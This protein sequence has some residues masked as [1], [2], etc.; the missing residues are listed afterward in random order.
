MD[1]NQVSAYKVIEQA[2]QAMRRGD[3]IAARQFA[4]Q[5]ALAAPELEEVW[6]TLA[7]LAAPRASVEY[8]QQALRIN[9]QSQRAQK[10]L[11]WAM[12]RLQAEQPSAAD[13]TPQ[14][15]EKPY[16]AEP[17]SPPR[18][19]L[20]GESTEPLSRPLAAALQPH[21]ARQNASTAPRR[22]PQPVKNQPKSRRIGK[23]IAYAAFSV[24]LICLVAGVL[25]ASRTTP[26]AALF[27]KP[28]SGPAWAPAV[29]SKGVEAPAQPPTLAPTLTFL[30]TA[31][32]TATASAT[33]TAAPTLT[34]TT[35]ATETPLPSA[36]PLPTFTPAPTDTPAPTETPSI[37]PTEGPS[38]TPLPTDTA[39]PTA[40]L[41]T[42][43]YLPSLPSSERWIEVNL[44]QQMVYAYE[45]S[46]LVNSF[47][48]ST[49]TAQT[50]T[51]TGS[52]RIY[53]KLRST[54][55]TGPGYY[56][57]NVPFTMYFYK[58]YG[59]HGTYWHSNF[60]TPMSHGCVNLS[61]P[62]AEWLYNWASVG[63]LVNIHY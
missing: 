24:L 14:P 35:A 60:G 48:V 4:E 41:P 8:L 30:P 56:L 16:R 50:P 5:A 54:T 34:G 58:S 20:T 59:L 13:A 62:D 10:G 6:L 53:I 49:G 36:T 63:T 37:T 45:G 25:L 61:T 52:Y 31:G 3:A 23:Q 27:S 12:G 28:V 22:I 11:I 40:V 44:S 38:P 46:T 29:V 2:Q 15:A 18:E 42:P 17:A 55:M 9:P 32:F 43:V 39:M 33:R 7:A 47:L 26:V 57:P 1:S 51:V 19:Q 21:P